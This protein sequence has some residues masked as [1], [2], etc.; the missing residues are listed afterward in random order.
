MISLHG[1]YHVTIIY[2]IKEM[3]KISPL[4]FKHSVKS[5]NA[6]S[7]W[8]T[9]KM[10]SHRQTEIFEVL[11]KILHY[12]RMLISCNLLLQHYL[13]YPGITHKSQHYIYLLMS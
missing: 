10:H 11:S 13:S 9:F 5:Y 7:N 12:T 3:L 1:P 6:H 4:D 2:Q 8:Q